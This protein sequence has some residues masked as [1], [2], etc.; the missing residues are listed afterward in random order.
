M[1]IRD[2]SGF[3]L[4]LT[5]IA[6]RA[7]VTDP[8][9]NQPGALSA[10]EIQAVTGIMQPR[11]GLESAL[12]L[13]A[14]G[15]RN[16]EHPMPAYALFAGPP[17]DISRR[18]SVRQQV[19][20]NQS[21]EAQQWRCG[22]LHDEIR[23]AANGLSHVFSYQATGGTAERS[24][25]LEVVDFMYSKCFGEKF[26]ALGGKPF[27]PSPDADY[28]S[29]LQDRGGAF[30]VSI[31]P[32][33]DSGGYWLERTDKGTDGCGFSIRL[34]RIQRLGV[35]LP[36]KYSEELARASQALQTQTERAKSESEEEMRAAV[37]EAVKA[38]AKRGP[39]KA[40]NTKE[41]VRL[42][43][44]G[45]AAVRLDDLRG[46]TVSFTRGSAQMIQFRYAPAAAAMTLVDYA[47]LNQAVQ[48][49]LQKRA[50]AVASTAHPMLMWADGDDCA[51]KTTH[52][53]SL[54]IG[55]RNRDVASVDFEISQ[56]DGDKK[57]YIG[58][59][60]NLT[61]PGAGFNETFDR[62]INVI[63]SAKQMSPGRKIVV[64]DKGNAE[65]MRENIRSQTFTMDLKTLTGTVEYKRWSGYTRLGKPAV[66]FSAPIQCVAY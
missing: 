6:S 63:G 35:T 4:L 9:P 24:S 29:V 8:F 66:E 28:V 5:A 46:K 11:L 57:W 48:A 21:R 50:D 20:C 64:V 3:I 13:V 12:Q 14:S 25:A 16:P 2:F 39:L 62:H 45:A 53:C 38:G 42:I 33:G 47:T 54:D 37:A 58:G 34:A 43:M 32:L 23:M 18:A 60:F 30:M 15:K 26:A 31:G 51:S 7:A 10:A 59:E 52:T 1:R 55:A 61:Q 41:G 65:L 44:A 22:P 27:K 49:M 17:A 40:C 36:A 56:K 19:I